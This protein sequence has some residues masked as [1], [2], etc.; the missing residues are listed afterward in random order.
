[1]AILKLVII[2]AVC[3]FVA[4][5]KKCLFCFLHC[6]CA[7]NNAIIDIPWKILYQINGK[8]SRGMPGDYWINTTTGVQQ[9]YCD[10]ELEC[11]GHKG[12][13]MRIAD[14]DTT[15]GDSCPTGWGSITSPLAAC[16]SASN[17]PGFHSTGFSVNGVSYHKVCGQ[18]RGYQVHA[19]N[20]FG[21]PRHNRGC[22]YEKDIYGAY[23]DGL[24]ITIGS[25]RKHV[26]TYAS[27]NNDNNTA[28]TNKT[29]D[30][31]SCPCAASY[32]VTCIKGKY[33]VGLYY[34]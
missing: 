3:Q 13:W 16:R 6:E 1:M 4:G 32:S 25:P 10:M 15:R 29:T 31:H 11:G 27:G 7:G 2:A 9:V 14:L 19:T 26:W 21:G 24:S 12:G 34:Y 17:N 22:T 5:Q 18:A 8:A 30:N 23:V 28:S 33:R 20:A